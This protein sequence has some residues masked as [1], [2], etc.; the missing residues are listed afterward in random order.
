MNFTIR[1]TR[2]SSRFSAR[3]AGALALITLGLA[4]AGFGL[5]FLVGFRPGPFEATSAYASWL[6]M[7]I[8]V[9]GALQVTGG[10]PV[11]LSS[12]IG[13]LSGVGGALLGAV[14]GLVAVVWAL[15]DVEAAAS[16]KVTGLMSGLIM[17][18]AYSA[19]GVAVRR[20]AKAR[21]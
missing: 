3:T 16:T 2:Q 21:S 17:I 8:V 12:R 19:I 9:F 6:G 15:M 13:S 5:G 1:P 10:I 7:A 11:F 18:V 4:T 14:V 20:P